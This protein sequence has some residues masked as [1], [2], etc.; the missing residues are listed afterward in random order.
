MRFTTTHTVHRVS[1]D[2][3]SPVAEN[4]PVHMSVATNEYDI[5]IMANL[6]WLPFYDDYYN[7]NM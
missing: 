6:I 1:P 2:A 7:T 5:F 3:Q 4:R